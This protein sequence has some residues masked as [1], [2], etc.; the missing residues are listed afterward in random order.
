[1]S[2]YLLL[3]DRL[4]KYKPDIANE[5]LRV[6]N[7]FWTHH[8]QKIICVHLVL[9][10]LNCSLKCTISF[11]HLPVIKCF[12]GQCFTSLWN[13]PLSS[14]IIWYHLMAAALERKIFVNMK[15]FN[16]H[17]LSQWLKLH[18]QKTCSKANWSLHVFFVLW[19]FYKWQISSFHLIL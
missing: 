10:L 3:L 17:T 19:C 5:K 7:C 12:S 2:P 11:E 16:M 18:V 15:E 8:P 4:W 1:M 6:L 14:L 9:N 13:L